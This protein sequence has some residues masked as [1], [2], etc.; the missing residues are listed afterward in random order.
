MLSVNLTVGFPIYFRKA[1]FLFTLTQPLPSKIARPLQHIAPLL[2]AFRD[3]IPLQ[4]YRPRFAPLTSI[5][6]A[7]AFRRALNSAG[8]ELASYAQAQSRSVHQSP[9]PT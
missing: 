1:L 2:I 9:P 3:H 5:S 7:L 8:A 6:A 4:Y